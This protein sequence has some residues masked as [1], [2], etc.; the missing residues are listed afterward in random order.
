M[1]LFP[2]KLPQRLRQGL[3]KVYL[4]AGQEPLLIEE[5]CDAIRSAAREADV[6][7]RLVLEADARF[8]WGQL[9]SATE[10]N[11]LFATQRLVEVRM[12]SGKPGRE[13]GAV[14]RE[15]AQ[16][17]SDDILLV[18]CDAWD[19]ASEKTAWVKA[20]DSA[21]VYVPCWKVKPQRLPQWIAQRLSSR[22]IRADQSACR[23]LAERLEGNLLAAAQEI[24]RLVLLYPGG[25]V[26][27]EE[28]RAAVADSAR[29]DSFR[30]I[31]LV[32]AG[33][34][35]AA[36]RCIRGLREAE[37]PMPLIV[38]A[39]ARE[40]Q[41][42]GNF[43]MLA[44]THPAAQAFKMLGIWKSRQQPVADAARRLSPE[45]VRRTLAQLSDLDQLSK[46]SGREMFWLRLERLC[47]ALATN[48]PEYCAA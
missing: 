41:T 38:G 16:A 9:G 2:E 44:R 23:F 31:E 20:L 48:R 8:D 22:G 12:P 24:E 39:L 47:V 42:I 32:F 30:L 5:A 28:V 15:W 18:K 10:T 19:M 43:Q 29:F 40:L 3:D 37:T 34:A 33:Q 26:G 1:K 35:G 13:G 25:Q 36:V 21:G 11:S 17:A 4:V 14:L 46:S 27:L 7:E 6:S 45:V